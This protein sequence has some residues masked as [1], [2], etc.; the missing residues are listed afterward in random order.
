MSD[1]L[2]IVVGNRYLRRNGTVAVIKKDL[3]TACG[4]HTGER[5]QCQE[6]HTYTERGK[7][8]ETMKHPL[9]LVQEIDYACES[10]SVCFQIDIRGGRR[11]PSWEAVEKLI[12]SMLDVP[13]KSGGLTRIHKR[14]PD[15]D[16]PEYLSGSGDYS[17]WGVYEL[18]YTTTERNCGGFVAGKK[19]FHIVLSFSEGE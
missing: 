15:P 14:G 3:G 13:E 5:Y 11:A 10:N 2:A 6:G 1:I 16:R 8:Y 18:T 4:Y 7:Y 19:E 17:S 9:D 12:R